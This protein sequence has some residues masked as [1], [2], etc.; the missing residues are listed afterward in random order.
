[1]KAKDSKEVLVQYMIYQ[2]QKKLDK[3]IAHNHMMSEHAS[4]HSEYMAEK[5]KVSATPEEFLY[6]DEFVGSI[7]IPSRYIKIGLLN[8]L[9][10]WFRLEENKQRIS[11][12]KEMGVGISLKEKGDKTTAFVTTRF[13]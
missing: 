7:T 13:R 5:D 10:K 11:G 6:S 8:L 4:K 3:E 2:I 1:M 12:A 9:Y